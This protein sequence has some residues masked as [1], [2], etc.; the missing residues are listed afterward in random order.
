MK[1]ILI[2]LPLLLLLVVSCTEDKTEISKS[3]S[4]IFIP[5]I[6]KKECGDTIYENSNGLIVKEK[7]F[8][9]VKVK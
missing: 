2:I 5:T 9:V 1:R 3:V 8:Y 7:N 6:L 4:R